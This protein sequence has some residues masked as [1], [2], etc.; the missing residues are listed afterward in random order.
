VLF[1]AGMWFQDLF[2]YDFRRTEMCIIPYGTQ[3]GEISFCAYNTGIGW[4]NIIEKMM[5]NASVAEWYRQHGR[6]PVYAKGKDFPMAAFSNPISS[7]LEGEPL[8]L[9]V[10]GQ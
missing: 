5:Q 6:H 9:R 1:V 4:R 3:L 7:R 8:R 10:I 2:N